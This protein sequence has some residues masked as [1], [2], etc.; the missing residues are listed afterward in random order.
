MSGA[1]SSLLR[2]TIVRPLEVTVSHTHT[3]TY[4]TVCVD[5]TG[6]EGGQEGQQCLK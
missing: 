2:S 3:L 6:G 1:V 5:T 4:Y